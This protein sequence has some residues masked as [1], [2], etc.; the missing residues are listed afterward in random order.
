MK[1]NHETGVNVN[2][3]V[4]IFWSFTINR[5]KKTTSC[6]MVFRAGNETRTRDP[7]LGRLML[8]QLSYSRDLHY[9]LA[10]IYKYLLTSFKK[11]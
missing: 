9:F 10:Q 1:Q 7:Q 6:E 3:C 8:Y 5:N 11:E 2:N 4:I